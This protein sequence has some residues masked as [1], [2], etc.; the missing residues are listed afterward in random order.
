MTH[1]YYIAEI[2][3]V[4]LSYLLTR[5]RLWN[6]QTVYKQREIEFFQINVN[7]GHI[8]QLLMKLCEQIIE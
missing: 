7:M 8:F 5:S 3:V 1:E 2:D 4:N 6:F